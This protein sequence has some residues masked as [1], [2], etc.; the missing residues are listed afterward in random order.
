MLDKTE[1]R[2]EIMQPFSFVV[3]DSEDTAEIICSYI[4]DSYPKSISDIDLQLDLEGDPLNKA[5]PRIQE[6]L[7]Q[8]TRTTNSLYDLIVSGVYSKQKVFTALVE[9]SISL[10]G[11]DYKVEGK[12]QE[13]HWVKKDVVDRLSDLSEPD[14]PKPST[15]IDPSVRY[16]TLDMDPKGNPMKKT[17][18]KPDPRITSLDYN[19]RIHKESLLFQQDQDQELAQTATQKLGK[20]TSTQ[21]V[22]KS[23][24]NMADKMS[25]Q[26]A[27][28]EINDLNDA[29]DDADPYS[30]YRDTIDLSQK[31]YGDS[32][33][34]VDSFDTIDKIYYAADLLKKLSELESSLPNQ[35]SKSAITKIKK[36]IEQIRKDLDII[37]PQIETSLQ[38]AT[39]Y[40][41]I[42]ARAKELENNMEQYT[43]D[44][45]HNLSE[46]KAI[47][48]KVEKLGKKIELM[49]ALRDRYAPQFD[50]PSLLP[51]YKDLVSMNMP[52]LIDIEGLQNVNLNAVITSW[53]NSIREY[54]KKLES[55]LDS[56]QENYDKLSSVL[57][58]KAKSRSLF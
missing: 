24:Q 14:Q 8:I 19:S 4:G 49:E 25:P 38:G 54:R 1:I 23:V 42:E 20:Q 6:E 33:V 7:P 45:T 16:S 11:N 39:G 35:K 46:W 52:S 5:I 2:K 9:V 12:P 47:Q 10:Q 48:S 43:D 31:W 44:Y 22:S 27:L 50:L 58:I 30:Q 56:F 36:E 29:L 34:L 28:D 13:F 3:S 40:S 26:R 17:K 53:R 41:N 21:Q 55:F 32:V 51:R 57:S 37:N 18:F 15:T